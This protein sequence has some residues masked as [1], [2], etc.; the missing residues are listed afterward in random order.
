MKI[1][2]LASR[3]AKNANLQQDFLKPSFV[4]PLEADVL[5]CLGGDGFLLHCLHKYLHLNKP[6][7]GLN[8]GSLGFLLNESTGENLI[9]KIKKAVAYKIHPLEANFT[10]NNNNHN[11]AIAFNEV[12]TLR[13]HSPASHLSIS[14]DDIERMNKLVADGIIVSTPL[15]STAYNRACGGHIIS[16]NTNL[17]SITPINPFSP[18]MWKGATINNNHIITIKNNDPETR[19]CNM[20][21]DFHE[22][23]D[24]ASIDIHLNKNIKVE[25]LFN[26]DNH[27]ED[28]IIK[29]QFNQL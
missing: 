25:I 20:F 15:G 18:I 2:C 7:Y 1:A 9:E 10:D 23:H 4:S 5:I 29:T 22:F 17:L 27:L 19:K 6:F 12:H 26:K 21:C 13:A 11:T 14:I 24:I 16:L 28:K 8:Y 3:F